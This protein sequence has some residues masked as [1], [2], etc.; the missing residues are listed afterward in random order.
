M[1]FQ[2]RNPQSTIRNPKSPCASCPACP[3]RRRGDF[4]EGVEGLLPALAP[5][6][7]GVSHLLG[8]KESL[9]FLLRE[10]PQL[11]RHLSHGPVTFIGQVCHMGRLVIPNLRG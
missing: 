10:Y 5:G 9:Q 1:P 8:I 7:A 2:I 3:A 11:L 6:N 4:I